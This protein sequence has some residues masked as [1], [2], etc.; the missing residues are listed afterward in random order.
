[1]K[2]AGVSLASLSN[3]LREHRRKRRKPLKKDAVPVF[4][5][6]DLSGVMGGPKWAAEMVLPDGSIVR[7]GAEVDVAL[8]ERVVR[9]LRRAC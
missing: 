8:A 1:M 6:V 7:L 4:Q 3:W 2:K 9:I 5:S